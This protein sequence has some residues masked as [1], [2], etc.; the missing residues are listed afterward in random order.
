MNGS[1]TSKELLRRS[2]KITS[3]R[4]LQRKCGIKQIE[5]QFQGNKHPLRSSYPLKRINPSRVNLSYQETYPLRSPFGI[6][7]MSRLNCQCTFTNIV[8]WVANHLQLIRWEIVDRPIVLLIL[9]VSIGH[10]ACNAILDACWECFN[11][12]MGHCRSLAI[13]AYHQYGIWAGRCGGSYKILLF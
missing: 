4:S 9:G 1:F 7:Q 10:N 11:C 3:P 12:T 6:I 13:T 5:L 2:K 8:A